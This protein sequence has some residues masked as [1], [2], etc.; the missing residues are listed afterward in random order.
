MIVRLEVEMVAATEKLNQKNGIKRKV[1][2][3]KGLPVSNE[4]ERKSKR[5]R[6]RMGGGAAITKL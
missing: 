2:P 6:E 5:E 3:N 4:E 1:I